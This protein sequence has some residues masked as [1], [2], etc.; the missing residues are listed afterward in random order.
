LPEKL[1]RMGRICGGVV[2]VDA[3]FLSNAVKKYLENRLFLGSSYVPPNCFESFDAAVN[4]KKDS[5]LVFG[6]NAEEKWINELYKMG[7]I[8][9]EQNAVEVPADFFGNCSQKIIDEYFVDNL[10]KLKAETK[11]WKFRG[12]PQRDEKGEFKRNPQR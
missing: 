7:R 11:K 10:K 8:S 4:G 9:S 3:E 1:A 12:N 5:Y 2:D 6:R